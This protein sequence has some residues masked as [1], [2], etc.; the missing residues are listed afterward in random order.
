MIA[1]T[2]RAA[3]V[4]TLH[5]TVAVLATTLLGADLLHN[6][7]ITNL[8]PW[9]ALWLAHWLALAGLPIVAL[10]LWNEGPATRLVAGLL[11]F[12]FATRG[13]PT[14]FAAALLA[15]ALL[16]GRSRLALRPALV[17]AVLALL[18]AGALASWIVTEWRVLTDPLYLADAARSPL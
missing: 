14:S 18:A 6:V 12:G 5:A 4:A 13:H 7:L 1:G 15:V 10:R 11:L 9:R 8:Q 17:D 2:A 3:V 16:A